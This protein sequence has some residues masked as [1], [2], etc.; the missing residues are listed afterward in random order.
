MISRRET[1]VNS[2]RRESSILADSQKQRLP[3]CCSHDQ[4]NMEH[5]YEDPS[6]EPRTL[7]TFQRGL[8]PY[9]SHSFMCSQILLLAQSLSFRGCLLSHDWQKF[10]G[11]GVNPPVQLLEAILLG[12]QVGVISP[13]SWIQVHSPNLKAS[14]S[15]LLPLNRVSFAS[16]IW[17]FNTRT[18]RRP[19]ASDL[20]SPFPFASLNP[21]KSLDAP[22]CDHSSWPPAKGRPEVPEVR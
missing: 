6:R 7:K 10:M 16:D 2:G 18:N 1:I 17:A 15:P 21:L 12:F 5:W 8:F 13:V 20:F 22:P 14:S 9:P 3:A 4:F 19:S 11:T